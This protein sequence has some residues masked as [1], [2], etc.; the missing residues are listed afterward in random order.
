M[1]ECTGKLAD[2][3]VLDRDFL[4]IPED[5]I[6]NVNVLM[7]VVG[8]KTVHLMPDFG[9]ENGLSPVGPVTWA[10]KPLEK[11]YKHRTYTPESLKNQF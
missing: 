2:F 6:P 10:S 9:K 11:Y 8:G 3:I 1:V 4:T 7:T 5:D